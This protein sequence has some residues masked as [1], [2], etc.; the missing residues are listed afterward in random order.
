MACFA[1]VMALRWLGVWV[2]I[3][4]AAIAGCDDVSG[5]LVGGGFPGGGTGGKE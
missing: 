1:R 4:L 5:G 3:A 2:G